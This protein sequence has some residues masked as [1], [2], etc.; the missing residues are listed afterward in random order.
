M[1]TFFSPK[2]FLRNIGDYPPKT[3]IM[4]LYKGGYGGRGPLYG[5]YTPCQRGSIRYIYLSPPPYELSTS[6]QCG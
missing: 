1:G 6:Y 5:G 4:T 3:D 2:I